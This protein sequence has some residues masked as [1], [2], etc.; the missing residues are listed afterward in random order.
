[1]SDHERFAQVT[2]QKW[3]PMS[4]SLR[5]LIFWQK[6]SDSL[7]KPMSEFLALHYGDECFG[8]S[9]FFNVCS[10]KNTAYQI[11]YRICII[12]YA[13]FERKKTFILRAD[14]IYENAKMPTP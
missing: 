7:I 9:F 10:M 14:T 8:P 4:E 5:L 1:M 6:K 11:V 13:I 12:F 3:A 2:N